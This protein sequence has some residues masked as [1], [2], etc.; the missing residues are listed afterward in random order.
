ME[1]KL[2]PTIDQCVAINDIELKKEFD[3]GVI[4]QLFDLNLAYEFRF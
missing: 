3:T 1:V 4:F 2:E